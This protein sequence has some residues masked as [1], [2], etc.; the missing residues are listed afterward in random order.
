MCRATVDSPDAKLPHIRLLFTVGAATQGQPGQAALH[1]LQTVA[2]PWVVANR[3]TVGSGGEFGLFSA[4][5]WL[6]GRVAKVFIFNT[7]FNILSQNSGELA[8]CETAGGLHTLPPLARNET[9]VDSRLWSTM[10][11]PY[12]E[13][14]SKRHPFFGIVY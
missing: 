6:F 2:Q 1:D 7:E 9:Y 8:A 11:H 12:C 5:C 4:V 10:I 13:F 3:T 14:Q